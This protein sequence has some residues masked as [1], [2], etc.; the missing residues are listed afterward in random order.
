MRGLQL[1]DQPS[2]VPPERGL[3]LVYL[4]KLASVNGTNLVLKCSS[5]GGRIKRPGGGPM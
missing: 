4:L 3:P 1:L 5:R 2:E